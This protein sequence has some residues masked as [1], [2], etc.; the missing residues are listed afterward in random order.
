MIFSHI[1]Q[2]AYDDLVTDMELYYMEEKN[3]S[4]VSETI[5]GKV[6]AASYDE[7]WF[8]VQVLSINGKND[9]SS[10]LCHCSCF[11]IVYYIVNFLLS[12]LVF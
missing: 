3:L 9:V 6:Y 2:N 5:V 12:I 1:W 10:F 4:P 7:S 11:W 8:R